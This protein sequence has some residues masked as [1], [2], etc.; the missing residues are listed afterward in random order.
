MHGGP[1]SGRGRSLVQEALQRQRDASEHGGLLTPRKAAAAGGRQPPSLPTSA[2]SPSLTTLQA[3]GSPGTVASQPA[4]G[5]PKGSGT[6]PVS[7]PYRGPVKDVGGSL[8]W[9]RHYMAL[10]RQAEERSIHG[11]TR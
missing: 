4:A 7:I 10:K 3:G 5:S 1:G 11:R 8:D 9:D 6:Q 2:S